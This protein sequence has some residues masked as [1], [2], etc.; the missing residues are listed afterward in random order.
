[1]N[2]TVSIYELKTSAR[3]AY[4]SQILRFSDQTMRITRNSSYR[5]FMHYFS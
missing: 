4:L 2:Y 3:K 5:A 1:M